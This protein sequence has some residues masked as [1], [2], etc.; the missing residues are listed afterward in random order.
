MNG[1]RGAERAPEHD[2]DHD[3][4]LH[5]FTPA[6]GQPDASPFVVK[7]LV[8]VALSGARARVVSPGR[9]P[10]APK[11]KLP[12]IRLPD[13]TRIGDS[14]LIHRHLA[15][16]HGLDLDSRLSEDERARGRLYARAAEEQLYFCLGVQRWI[17]DAHYRRIAI[18]YFERLGLPAPLGRILP[19]LI[20]RRTR[21]ALHAQGIGRHAIADVYAFGVE[22]LDAFERVLGDGPFL[23][24]EHLSRADT[25]VAPMIDGCA[26]GDFDT[27]LVHRA[28]AP[29]LAAYAARVRV[30][31]ERLVGTGGNDDP[32][33]NAPP[34]AID[35]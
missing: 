6:L 16:H 17:P 14:E 18:A 25:S 3:F 32:P 31:A 19:P 4:E 9:I 11:G 10:A 29:A 34:R 28:A 12:Y 20:R 27:P 23:F 13:G 33:R 26:A 15:A 35:S 1:E 5:C 22:T 30:H 24:G 8:Q 7:T 21:R 2:T